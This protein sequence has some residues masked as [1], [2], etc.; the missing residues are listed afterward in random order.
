M[1]RPIY[2]V[3]DYP[4]ID[5]L[6]T[7]RT[8]NQASQNFLAFPAHNVIFTAVV[9]GTPAVFD[10]VVEIAY[11]TGSGDPTTIQPMQT[12]YISTPTGSLGDVG[13]ARI[14][15]AITD[16]PL[17]IG[18]TSDLNL[19]DGQI[20][21]VTDEV[22]PW[23]RHL[24]QTGD[25]TCDMDYDIP[26]S[27]QYVD[28]NPV[29]NLGPDA[30]LYSPDEALSGGHTLSITFDASGSFMP[31]GSSIDTFTWD[32]VAGSGIS[33]TNL[34]TDHPTFT[35]SAAGT[36]RVF[37]T[38]LGVN[39]ATTTGYRTIC[40][41]D[42]D[43][44]PV[45]QFI[46]DQAPTGSR[47]DGGW[48]FAVTMYDHAALASVKDRQPVILF[49]R[50][51]Y[52]DI[53]SL[54]DP[55]ISFDAATKRIIGTGLDIFPT[56][57]TIQIT[58]STDGYNDGIY[59]VKIGGE[60]TYIEINET[61]L[62]DESAGESITIK[63]LNGI[64]DT[65]LGPVKG[66]ENI[67]CIGY[68]EKDSMHYSPD[69]SSVTFTVMGLNYWL[70]KMPKFVLGIED[71]DGVVGD[72]RATSWYEFIG[73]TVDAGLFVLLYWHSTVMFFTDVY[74]T[75]DTRALPSLDAPEGSLWDQL[76]I[77]AW[78]TIF[79]LPSCNCYGQLYVE[80]DPQMTPTA[81]RDYSTWVVMDAEKQDCEKERTD[82]ARDITPRLSRLTASGVMYSAGNNG[83]GTAL[84]AT[85]PGNVFKR[86]GMTEELPRLLVSSQAQL[87]EL[88]GLYVARANN[89]FPTVGI[90]LVGNNR[91]IDICPRQYFHLARA[92]GDT[93]RGV[94]IDCNVIPVRIVRSF[95]NR[96]GSYSVEITG[97]A[98]TFPDLSVTGVTPVPAPTP[99]D[100]TIPTFDFPGYTPYPWYPPVI[101]D[102]NVKT[103]TWA[104][105]TPAIGGVVGPYLAN[106]FTAVGVYT[107]CI[108]GTSVSFNV[109]EKVVGG[110]SVDIMGSEE[111]AYPAYTTG[112]IGFT[113]PN[114]DAGKWLWLD[115]S[116]VSGAVTQV[117]VTVILQ[118]A[119]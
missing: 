25:L 24:V 17:L 98:E 40:A 70:A 84:V 9:D 59:T 30:V 51:F 83:I 61:T 35:V 114:L 71:W 102:S 13:M 19:A 111:V 22:L 43:N 58:G 99:P 28:M 11:R 48:Q 23:A 5:E 14:R 86:F 33:G 90:V 100:I 41:Y 113:N 20:L 108:G 6:T 101:P 52:G 76:K 82:I 36:W 81:E 10:R 117:V 16:T 34:G 88:A 110:S 26:Y 3:L 1:T 54:T 92:A 115:I 49:S 12:L 27:G 29:A 46:F 69:G 94:A 38:I 116:N 91:F 67:V 45:S 80:I 103:Y 44:P 89:N 7:L 18:E 39:N 64:T 87:N 112:V 53:T 105:K 85:A 15:A 95:D 119:P 107:Y 4:E 56:N 97:E 47:D 68:I 109:A 42:V 8:N 57:A 32:I 96:T 74:L 72:S 118:V 75:G 66:R 106:N 60:A 78:D 73:L 2:T 37:C 62:V 77:N 93:P 63:I 50:D 55:G 31:D 21:T 104:L 65:S 79:A